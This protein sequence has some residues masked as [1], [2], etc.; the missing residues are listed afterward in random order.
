[1]AN[2][3]GDLDGRQPD[4]EQLGNQGPDQGYA[5]TLA[6]AFRGTLSLHPG[7]HEDDALAG[8]VAVGL[9]R[10]SLF[11]RAPVAHDVRV[12]LGIWGFL[13]ADAPKDLVEVRHQRFEEVHHPYQYSKLRAV[14]DAVPAEV[15]RQPHEAILDQAAADWTSVI[16]I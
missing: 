1:M 12:G 2:R 3:P 14:A 13:D 7:E 10:A 8:A 6:E 9:K 4:G 11:G 5:L 15:L 16:K